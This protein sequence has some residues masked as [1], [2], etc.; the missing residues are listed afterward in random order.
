MHAKSQLDSTPKNWKSG[1]RVKGLANARYASV[2]RNMS[3]I[4]QF[5][6]IPLSVQ[7]SP[8]AK[9]QQFIQGSQI[10]PNQYVDE[11][12]SPYIVSHN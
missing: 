11:P 5:S 1:K 7:H 4:S 2:D 3:P 12:N 6:G 8:K 9:F 10:K